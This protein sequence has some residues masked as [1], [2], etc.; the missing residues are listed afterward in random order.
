M[1][2][3]AAVRLGLRG[4]SSKKTKRKLFAGGPGSRG[5]E[6]EMKKQG[7]SYLI[8]SDQTAG[9]GVRFCRVKSE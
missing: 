1:Q 8:I 4:Y 6:F 5:T 9:P 3:F 7:A 2:N